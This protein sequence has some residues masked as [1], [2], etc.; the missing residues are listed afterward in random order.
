MTSTVIATSNTIID[1]SDTPSKPYRPN[2]IPVLASVDIYTWGVSSNSSE[3]L[4]GMRPWPT[5]PKYSE[6][7]KPLSPLGKV[8][9][10]VYNMG[11]RELSDT[12]AQLDVFISNAFPTAMQVTLESSVARYL[13]GIGI[14]DSWD[15][16]KNIWQTDK[17]REKEGTSLVGSWTKGRAFE[18]GW[19]WKMIEEG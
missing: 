19:N 3:L 17:N 4:D 6:I 10:E 18:E 13:G 1:L 12:A 5:R 2:L 14:K 7:D 16:E 11:Y 9:D 8:A 15:K